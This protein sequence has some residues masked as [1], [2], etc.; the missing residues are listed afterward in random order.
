MP[1]YNEQQI[2]DTI[3]K[4][5]YERAHRIEVH[6][7]LGGIPSLLMRTSWVE[8]DN[9]TGGGGDGQHGQASTTPGGAGVPNT[10]GGGG[11]SAIASAASNAPGGSGG[12]GIVIVRYP[13]P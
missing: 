9:E 1:L 13:I 12:S 4:T 2:T 5:R 10:G 6:N 3:D 8:R 11:G 7:P